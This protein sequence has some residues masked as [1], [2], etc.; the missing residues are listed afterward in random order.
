VKDEIETRLSA[1]PNLGLEGPDVKEIKIALITFAYDNAKVIN[2]LR[3]RGNCIK[4][5]DWDGL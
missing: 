1:M 4:L 5:E 3:E 2:W